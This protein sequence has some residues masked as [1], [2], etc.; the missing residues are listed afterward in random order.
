MA[1]MRRILH[2]LGFE[3]LAHRPPLSQRFW[4]YS[5]V[6]YLMPVA[7]QV[8]F[9]EDPTKTDE[10][11][12]LVTLVPAFMLSVHYGLRGAFAAV[13]MGTAL[14]IVVQMVVALNF[15]PD[16]WRVTV[17]IYMA[18]GAIAISVGRLSDDLHEHYRKAIE[19]ER[20]AV[21]GQLAL[22][23]EHE[24][25]NALTAVVAESQ[26][27]VADSET[28][29]EDQRESVG[30]IN[31]SAMRMADQIARLTKLETAP[32]VNHLGVLQRLDLQSATDRRPDPARD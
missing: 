29:S 27:L 10:L 18:Y 12:W 3:P 5:A 16:D 25:N 2:S 20:M 21:I 1:T 19:N 24:I 32:V 8:A 11:I 7:V 4:I 22:A 9:P 17:P 6:A 26:L 14:F 28:L 31:K 15:T 30:V 13:V 23:I